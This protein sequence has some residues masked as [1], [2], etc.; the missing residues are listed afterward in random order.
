MKNTPFLNRNICDMHKAYKIPNIYDDNKRFVIIN[1]MVK[2]NNINERF[3]E[4]DV[5]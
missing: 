5:I 3:L 4:D 2:N 1:D